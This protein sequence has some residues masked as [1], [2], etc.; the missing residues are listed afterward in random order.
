MPRGRPAKKILVSNDVCQ[1]DAK[2]S[3]SKQEDKVESDDENIESIIEKR[4]EIPCTL[5][6]SWVS[7]INKYGYI[8][9]ENEEKSSH[10]PSYKMSDELKVSTIHSQLVQNSD[11]TFIRECI[12]KLQDIENHSVRHT[13]LHFIDN[14][15]FGPSREVKEQ[16]VPM[17]Q[18]V[19]QIN[20]GEPVNTN[21]PSVQYKFVY[22]YVPLP[23]KYYKDKK[24]TPIRRCKLILFG[25]I[26]MKYALYRTFRRVKQ[27]AIIHDMERSCYKQTIDKSE[28]RNIISSWQN[29]IF[30][31]LYNDICY[32]IAS[33]LDSTF[34]SSYYLAD[35]VLNDKI[36]LKTIAGLSTKELCP[37]K[38]REISDKIERAKNIEIKKNTTSLYMCW[39]CK[40]FECTVE[41][42]YAAAG[43]ESIPLTV[44]CVPCG[45]VMFR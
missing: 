15:L 35:L 20:T 45:N 40:K 36:D 16:P 31:E 3:D 4:K 8:K 14:A 24:Y 19:Q 11:E 41:N 39:K 34:I 42:R 38:Y 32:K 25:E 37:D 5:E 2:L 6:A 29:P 18:E 43:D 22:K 44:T 1:D 26:L 28:K 12:A 21:G 33:N 7:A 30:E 9:T 17:E 13:E 23:A 27:I 10:H